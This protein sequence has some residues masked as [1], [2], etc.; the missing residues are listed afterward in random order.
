MSGGFREWWEQRGPDLVC[1]VRAGFLEEVTYK[2]RPEKG[3]EVNQD[4]GVLM[5]KKD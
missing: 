1:V 3:V 2:P 5:E 4:R